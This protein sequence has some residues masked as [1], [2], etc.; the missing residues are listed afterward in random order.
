VRGTV[1]HGCDISLHPI[2]SWGSEDTVRQRPNTAREIVNPCI[3]L[4]NLYGIRDLLKERMGRSTPGVPEV[5]CYSPAVP[6]ERE[7]LQGHVN[8]DTGCKENWK[9]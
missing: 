5:F 7:A 3:P 9:P 2:N 8:R 1:F 6:T 4:T